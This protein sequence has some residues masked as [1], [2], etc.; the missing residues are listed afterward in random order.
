MN[1]VAGGQKLVVLTGRMNPVRQR[2]HADAGLEVNQNARPGK[3]GMPC[4]ACRELMMQIDSAGTTEILQDYETK[5]VITLKE[6]LPD[7]W[8]D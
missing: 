1:V 5:K 2:N 3:A 6:T 4:G 7:W 8:K